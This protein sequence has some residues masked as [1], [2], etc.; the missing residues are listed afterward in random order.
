[1]SQNAYAKGTLRYTKAGLVMLFLYLLWGD[2]CTQLLEIVIPSIMPLQLKELKAS[3][4]VMGLLMSTTPFV[5]NLTA[6]PIVSFWSDNLRTRWGRRLPILFVTA[7]FCTL[8]LI[9]IAFAPEISSWMRQSGSIQ[10][11]G[12]S[13]YSVTIITMAGLLILF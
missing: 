10:S 2:F 3:N 6:N 5:F 12:L 8:F 11:L 13:P 9:L 4:L 7:P 1:M